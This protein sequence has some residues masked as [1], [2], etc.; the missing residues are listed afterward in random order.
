MLLPALER[1]VSTASEA[2]G[3]MSLGRCRTVL[4]PAALSDAR[5]W[6]TRSPLTMAIPRGAESPE[7]LLAVAATR[8]HSELG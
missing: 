7:H 4:R 8:T 1:L 2:A 6:T 3:S 5:D